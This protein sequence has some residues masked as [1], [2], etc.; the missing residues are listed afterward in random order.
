MRKPKVSEVSAWWFD[1]ELS[2]P[3]AEVWWSEDHMGD[4]AKV[5][6]KGNKPKYFFGESAWSNARRWAD[7]LENN[8]D[9]E[10]N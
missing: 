1:N 5:I 8:T 6:S 9:E 10:T 3:S 7:D 4:F 2:N